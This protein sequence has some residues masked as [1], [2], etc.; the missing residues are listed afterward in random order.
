MAK[1][2]KEDDISQII[3]DVHSYGLNT[4]T[5]E[6]FL[7]C[8]T[9]NDNDDGGEITSISA[10]MFI[11][12]LKILESLSKDPIVIHQYSVGG[13][14]NSGMAI[15]DSILKSNCYITFVTHGIAASMGSIIPQAADKRLSMFDCEWL[16]HDGSLEISGNY[17]K[18]SSHI[19]FYKRNR[20]RMLEIYALRTKVSEKKLKSMFSLK[21]DWLLSSNEALEYGFIDEII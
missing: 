10:A 3:H 15:Y 11:K 21:E 13:C 14:W 8:N 12:N 5:R 7:C 4:L 2:K 19:D 16:I 6:I 9:H 1:S 17:K 18:V 20:Q